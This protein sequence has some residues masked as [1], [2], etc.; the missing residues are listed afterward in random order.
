ML[1]KFVQVS[2]YVWSR[3]VDVRWDIL[4]QMYE[5]CALRMWLEV[6]ESKSPWTIFV[7]LVWRQGKA[8]CVWS[9]IQQ[10][11]L[12]VCVSG[13]CFDRSS[14]CVDLYG[15]AMFASEVKYYQVRLEVDQ[16][17]F[18][19]LSVLCADCHKSK[20]TDERCPRCG[21]G[22]MLTCVVLL[23]IGEWS[24]GL[25]P[26]LLMYGDDDLFVCWGQLKFSFFWPLG[27]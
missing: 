24:C 20:S 21:A 7:K 22:W 5:I 15:W 13:Q 19:G 9:S 27:I 4:E 6:V 2:N 14:I 8:A 17:R 1:E 3:W 11:L 18:L 26:K 10:G 23:R 25:S 16:L 12:W